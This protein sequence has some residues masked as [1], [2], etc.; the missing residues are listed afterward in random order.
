M[1]GRL[2]EGD[3]KA[4]NAAWQ[5]GPAAAVG[6]RALGSSAAPSNRML[7]IWVPVITACLDVCCARYHRLRA[8]ADATPAAALLN[9]HLTLR[10]FASS[11]PA[12]AGRARQ[13]GQQR[14]RQRGRAHG[15]RNH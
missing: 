5:G 10:V 14:S 11:L 13:G 3:F 8:T 15:G 12:H 1:Q 4:L 2:G 6:S 7:S 9:R